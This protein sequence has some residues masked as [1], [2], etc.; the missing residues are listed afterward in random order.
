MILERKEIPFFILREGKVINYQTN[1]A[2]GGVA[3]FFDGAEYVKNGRFEN[4]ILHFH[5]DNEEF[6]LSVGANSAAIKSLLTFFHQDNGI[7]RGD[8]IE[9]WAV[10]S[11]MEDSDKIATR[12][13]VKH[14]GVWLKK[15]DG[16]ETVTAENLD[17]KLEEFL[18]K[19]DINKKPTAT[20][21][22]SAEVF[23]VKTQAVSDT[24]ASTEASK[25]ADIDSDIPF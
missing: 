7:N 22:A 25:Q 10:G 9:I 15:P 20:N 19:F 23:R 6:R 24:P 21:E 1:T 8:W 12:V 11:E 14:Q 2:H 16:A 4:I 13:L 18:F 3:G 17:D 5:D